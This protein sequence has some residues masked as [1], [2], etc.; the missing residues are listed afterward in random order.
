MKEHI[1]AGQRVHVYLTQYED[2]FEQTGRKTVLVLKGT[3]RHVSGSYIIVKS[4]EGGLHFINRNKYQL[5]K[6][7]QED[8]EVSS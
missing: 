2:M 7:S 8:I 4:D 5:E 6:V 3:A 1:N